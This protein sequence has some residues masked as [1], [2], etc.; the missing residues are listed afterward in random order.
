MI[1]RRAFPVEVLTPHYLIKGEMEPIG[2]ML[3]YLNDPERR[4][5][6]FKKAEALSIQEGN[7]A[8]HFHAEA[9]MVRQENMIA[10]RLA[11][12]V[13]QSTMPLLARK[14]KIRVFTDAFVIQGYFHC[15]Q[16]V[17]LNDIFDLAKGDWVPSSEAIVHALF[18]LKRPVFDSAPILIINRRHMH[19]YQPVKT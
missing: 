6:V 1:Q 3:V 12:K 18:Q 17:Q 8:S 5:Y 19:F 7:L 15:G 13:G 14:E 9:L 16:D 11:E 10:I 4:T 2:P